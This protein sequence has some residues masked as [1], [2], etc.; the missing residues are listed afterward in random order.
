MTI[1]P[2]RDGKRAAQIADELRRD[3][4]RGVLS[5]GSILRQEE[6]AHRFNASRTPIRDSLRQL[7]KQGLVVMPTNK[8]AEVTALN[9][10]DFQE[11]TDMRALAEP[12]ALRHA[13][14]NLTNRHL[15]QAT[16]LQNEAESAPIERFSELNRQFHACLIQPCN[17]PRLLA[18]L[19]YLSALN[20]RYLHFAAIALDYVDRSHGEHRA[21]LEA[22]YARDADKACDLL[23][24]HI[25]GV[26][27]SARTASAM[28]G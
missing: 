18:H 26:R 13:I 22:C 24:Q 6:L 27:I 12:L 20:E 25:T 17:R 28:T 2:K 15:Q 4:I 16:E 14:P 1:S 9:A 8:G 11:I 19:D 3:I 5:P 10:D 23:Q 21:L 7:E